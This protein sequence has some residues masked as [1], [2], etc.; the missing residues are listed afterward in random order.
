MGHGRGQVMEPTEWI[1]LAGVLSTATV[2]VVVPAI[3]YRFE[4]KRERAR[5]EEERLAELRALLDESAVH[6]TQAQAAVHDLEEHTG[7]PERYPDAAQ[8]LVKFDE[9]V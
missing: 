5:V 6:L 9:Q 7:A 2:A 4:R 1:A 3:S 8:R